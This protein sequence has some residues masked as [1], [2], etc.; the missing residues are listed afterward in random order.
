MTFWS[1]CPDRPRRPVGVLFGGLSAFDVL[2][3]RWD[4]RGRGGLRVPRYRWSAWVLSVLVTAAVTVV[5][6]APGVT[7]VTVVSD[8][9][10]QPLCGRRYWCGRTHSPD[11]WVWWELRACLVRTSGLGCMGFA[12]R[13]GY[14]RRSTPAVPEDCCRGIRVLRDYRAP[15]ASWDNGGWDDFVGLA[16]LA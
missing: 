6:T 7:F 14:L 5:T 13:P 12:R 16:R 9:P 15:P 11:P 1:L 3:C 8:R 2:C 4:L 10:L